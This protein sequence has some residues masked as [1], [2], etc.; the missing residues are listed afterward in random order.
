LFAAP[1]I[2]DTIMMESWFLADVDAVGAY[3]DGG[4]KAAKFPGNDEDIDL[5]VTVIHY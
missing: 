2:I 1:L 4:L 3:F 5:C